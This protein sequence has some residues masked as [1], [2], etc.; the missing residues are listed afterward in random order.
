MARAKGEADAERIR[1]EGALQAA[2]LLASNETAVDLAKLRETGAALG[3]KGTNSF[4]F[5]QDAGNLG[6]LLT[7]G[8]A[9]NAA[10]PK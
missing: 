6:S 5:G 7:A 8:V 10:G 9:A 1:A 4:F 3:T 2:E